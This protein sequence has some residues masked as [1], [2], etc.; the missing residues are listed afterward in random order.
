MM[1]NWQQPDWPNFSWDKALL[2]KAEQH[3][4]L[5]DSGFK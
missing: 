5:S 2:Q 3:F 4:L 1:W